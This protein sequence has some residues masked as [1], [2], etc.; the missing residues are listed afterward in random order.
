VSGPLVLV[1]RLEA[2]IAE[3]EAMNRTLAEDLQA[4][5]TRLAT[6][7]AD[8]DDY[9][10]R[11]LA[12]CREHGDAKRRLVAAHHELGEHSLC[13]GDCSLEP[14]DPEPAGCRWC[15]RADCFN[16]TRREDC[17]SY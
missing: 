16:R 9:E 15:G 6:A 12:E 7:E 5:S 10:R 8:R 11:W 2:R 13:D 3:L 17:V 4:V 14:Q 1:T